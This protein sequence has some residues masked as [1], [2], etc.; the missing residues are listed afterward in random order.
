MAWSLVQRDGDVVTNAEAEF[1]FRMATLHQ[2][3]KFFDTAELKHVQ[4][5]SLHQDLFCR[6]P[7]NNFQAMFGPLMPNWKES[8][9]IFRAAG[10]RIETSLK[11]R[12]PDLSTRERKRREEWNSVRIHLKECEPSALKFRF[13]VLEG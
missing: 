8:I 10:R 7:G 2:L 5:I 1:R 3:L 12:L 9:I 4:R 6:L 11:A 13:A